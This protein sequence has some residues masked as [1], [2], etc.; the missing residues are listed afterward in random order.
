M[1]PKVEAALRAELRGDEGEVLK[2]Y[3]DKTGRPVGAGSTLQGN[4]TIGVGRNLAARGLTLTESEYLLANDLAACEGELS[5]PLPWITKLSTGRQTVIY[6]LYFNVGLGNPARFQAKWPNFLAQMAAGQFDQA[7][8][9]LEASQ[10][11]ATEVGP[12]ARRL[13]ELVRFG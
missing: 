13:G 3:D 7:A 5:G 9:N 6:S 12:R 8:D 2:V 4:P 11:W 10:P 1:D